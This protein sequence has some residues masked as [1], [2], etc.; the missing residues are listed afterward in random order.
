MAFVSSRSRERARR[1]KVLIL[2]LARWVAI[3][4][5]FG[6]IGYSSYQGGLALAELKV[7]RLRQDLTEV[8]RERDGARA[9]QANMQAELGKA[10]EQ[11]AQL[12]ASYAADVPTGPV[13]AILQL[14]RERIGE[15]LGAER[16]ME[17]LRAVRA[18]VAC[19]GRASTKR[20][21]LR[22]GAQPLAEDTVTFADGLITLYV[23]PAQDDP[24]RA[25]T[26]NFTRIGGV[27]MAVSGAPPLR[28]SIT[29]EN[30]E[31]RFVIANSEL[32]G[33]VTA[34]VNTCGR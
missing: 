34:T 21:A 16:I 6:G 25:I 15:G 20:F 7:V 29:I 26:A 18:I 31:L 17:A 10:Q 22:P 27:P 8:T 30:A 19:E 33:F 24:A 32:R 9:A 14:A 3:A 13:A 28:A 1:R 5:A 4:V 23:T 2:R 12:Q 11:I